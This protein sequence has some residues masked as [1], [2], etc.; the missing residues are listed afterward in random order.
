MPSLLVQCAVQTGLFKTEYLVSVHHGA[1]FYV[2]R[3]DVRV[4]TPPVGN[5]T[6]D[7]Q[8]IA[9]LLEYIKDSAVLEMTGTPIDGGLRISV[10]KALT[11]AA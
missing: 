3:E 2:D 9:Y 7:G 8:V 5:E 6:V 10:P 1:R 4:N 11:T